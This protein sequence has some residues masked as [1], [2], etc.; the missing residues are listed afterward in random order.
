MRRCQPCERSAPGCTFS[1]KKGPVTPRIDLAAWLNGRERGV[2]VWHP[3]VGRESVKG[4]GYALSWSASGHGWFGRSDEGV[5][6]FVPEALYEAWLRSYLERRGMNLLSR[7]QIMRPAEE[8]W[9]RQSEAMLALEANL[10]YWMRC[11]DPEVQVLLRQ[12]R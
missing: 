2:K 3:Q 10:G 1:A 6:I 9:Q 4:E 5:V 11:S 8:A 7:T 12:S